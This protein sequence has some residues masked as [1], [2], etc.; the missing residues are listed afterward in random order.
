MDHGTYWQ[1]HLQQRDVAKHRH[2]VVTLLLLLLAA[3]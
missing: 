1:L 3:S 2:V